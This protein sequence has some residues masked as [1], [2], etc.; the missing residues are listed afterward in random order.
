MELTLPR[1]VFVIAS[2]LQHPK[3]DTKTPVFKK[4]RKAL[5]KG[6]A[7]RR[8]IKTI[9]IGGYEWRYHATRGWRR[10]KA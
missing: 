3:K 1:A 8:V 2:Y 5:R 4:V 7:N 6:V 9:I 10:N